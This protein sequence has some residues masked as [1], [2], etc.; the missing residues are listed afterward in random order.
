MKG[1]TVLACLANGLSEIDA[2]VL[3][4]WTV[5]DFQN[6]KKLNDRFAGIVQRKKIEYKETLMKPITEAIKKGDAKMAQWMLERQFQSEFSSKKRE[7]EDD[8]N[9]MGV[10]INLIQQGHEGSSLLPRTRIVRE[11][12]EDIQEYSSTARV[13]LPTPLVKKKWKDRDK[14]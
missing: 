2:L 1:N 14:N 12:Q 11:I 4:E 6:Y 13:K 5:E 7:S 8:K 9:P 3:A 10:I